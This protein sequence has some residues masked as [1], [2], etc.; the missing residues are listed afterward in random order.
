MAITGLPEVDRG[1]TTRLR[2]AN[3]GI[4]NAGVAT[5]D[6]LVRKEV[7]E[8]THGR[9][10]GKT[11]SCVESHVAPKSL[12]QHLQTERLSAGTDDPSS[13]GVDDSPHPSD[14][15]GLMRQRQTAAATLLILPASF[16][17]VRIR[18]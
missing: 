11:P 5:T 1:T 18:P 12:R 17:T 10:R 8:Q 2:A 9:R 3:V 6:D 13:T 7:G 4:A 16:L 15:R 14:S